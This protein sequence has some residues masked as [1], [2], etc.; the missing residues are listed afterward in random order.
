M[1]RRIGRIGSSPF[2]VHPRRVGVA[3][4]G[5]QC[6]PVRHNAEVRPNRAADELA[7]REAVLRRNGRA[8]GVSLKHSHKSDDWYDCERPLT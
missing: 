5:G 8:E 4:R 1:S 7:L 3:Q 6:L 2:P